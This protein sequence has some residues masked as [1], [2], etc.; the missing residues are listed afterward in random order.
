MKNAIQLKEVSIML[1]QKDMEYNM[2]RS[3]RK[4]IAGLEE[5]LE[6]LKD[7]LNEIEGIKG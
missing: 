4:F 3:H 2:L 7:D 1:S 5:T 6:V